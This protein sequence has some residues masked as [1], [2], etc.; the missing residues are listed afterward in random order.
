MKLTR[1]V[2]HP[3]HSRST[4]LRPKKLRLSKS[5]NAS[6]VYVIGAGFS[7]GLGF[8]M[9][10]DLL[11]KVWDRLESDLREK[12][13]KIIRFHHPGFDPTQRTT[14][15]ELEPLLS[16]MEANRELFH[17]TRTATGKFKPKD[18]S[19]A[20]EGLLWHVAQWF[21]EIHARVR[22]DSN[23]WVHKFAEGVRK[24]G[25]TIISFNWDLVLDE[26]LLKE[27]TSPT[28]Y[29]FQGSA[30]GLTLLK[31]HGSLNWFDEK[32]SK[33]LKDRFKVPLAKASGK[34]TYAFT[35]FRSPKSKIGNRY[36][37]LIV[38]P[39]YMK[40]FDQPGFKEVWNTCVSKLSTAREVIFIG[41]SLP[42]SD[43]HARFMLRCA[44]HNSEAFGR[45]R[46]H[47]RKS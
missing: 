12:L 24:D 22:T 6:R 35:K 33:R 45:A 28:Q 11:V 36:Q 19:E 41:Y 47:G 15:P 40:R 10:N 29:G 9:T 21:E 38:P 42:P 46:G 34:G 13:V 8:P 30:E 1:R 25:S 16:S 31:P 32:Q 43:F 26:L 44:F 14:F 27:V 7:A 18:I 4:M 39:H 23:T 20:T 3:L 17:H 37:P 2:A 5:K